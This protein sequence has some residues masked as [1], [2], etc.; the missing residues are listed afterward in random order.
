M[1]GETWQEYTES[2]NLNLSNKANF[3]AKIE[4]K[5]NDNQTSEEN[6][7]KTLNKPISYLDAIGIKFSKVTWQSRKASIEIL[8][9]NKENIEYQIN[10]NTIEANWQKGYNVSN[11]NHNDILYARLKEGSDLID[12]AS[13]KIE[14]II[15]PT[16]EIEVSKVNAKNITVNIT[17]AEDNE[18]GIRDYTYI[19]EKEGEIINV[20]KITKE[21]NYNEE[22]KCYN[23]DNASYNN[24]I[25][26][27]SSRSSS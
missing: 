17:K 15:P 6:K 9:N 8:A 12:E 3:L 14:D 16:V 5:E 10:D 20:G 11:L 25:I 2:I 22:G 26:N 13:I 1:V 23:V 24:N 27:N 18:T 7:R 4:Y 21:Q 19:V